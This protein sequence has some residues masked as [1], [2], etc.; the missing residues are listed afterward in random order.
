MELSVIQEYI[1]PE[2][3]VLIPVLYIIGLILKSAS[4]IPDKYIPLLL[5]LFGVLFCLMYMAATMTL[6]T[7]QE[8]LLF[9]FVGLTQGFLVAGAAVFANQIYKQGT[10]D[11]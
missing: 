10:K 8:I 5:G 1:R 3:I 4:A 9:V 11:D 6:G 2:V 7:W